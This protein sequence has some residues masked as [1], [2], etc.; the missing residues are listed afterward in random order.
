MGLR[1]EGVHIAYSKEYS[2]L[3]DPEMGAKFNCRYKDILY[4]LRTTNHILYL[5]TKN[6]TCVVADNLVT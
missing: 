6:K 2:C 1:L 3:K 4:P 5:Q